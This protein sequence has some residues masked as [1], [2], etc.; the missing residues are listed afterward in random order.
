MAAAAAEM[1]KKM[2]FVQLSDDVYEE[3]EKRSRQEG[4]DTVDAYIS[5]VLS[6]QFQ[7]TPKAAS[8]EAGPA[9]GEDAAAYIRNKA[10]EWLE[11]RAKAPAADEPPSPEIAPEEG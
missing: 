9:P 5:Q 2:Q 4:F 7:P 6:N 3:A 1:T 10:K 8:F 11:K